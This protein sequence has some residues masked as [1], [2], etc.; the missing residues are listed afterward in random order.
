ML[1]ELEQKK[2]KTSNH[3]F[4]FPP[5]HLCDSLSHSLRQREKNRN[6]IIF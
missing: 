2:E 1:G 4:L 6:L 5:F 3:P